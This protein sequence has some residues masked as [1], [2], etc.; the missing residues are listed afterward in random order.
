MRILLLPLLFFAI[1]LSS[2]SKEDVSLPDLATDAFYSSFE[3]QTP[4][5]IDTKA[6]TQYSSANPVLHYV[7]TN[8][9]VSTYNTTHYDADV[10]NEE[11][12]TAH[13]KYN[14]KLSVPSGNT[15]N[16]ITINGTR[17]NLLQFHFHWASEHTIDGVKSAMEVHLVHQST[18]GKLAV[19]GVLINIGAKNNALQ[20]VFDAS[21]EIDGAA[22]TLASF[23]PASLLPS[24]LDHYF[25]Y[26]GSLT[27]PGGG[28]K[29]LPY[30]EGLDW[31]VYKAPLTIT[32]AQLDQYVKI[33][34]EP[35]A[36]P[37]QPL[38]GRTVLYHVSK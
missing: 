22:N 32:A 26:S 7:S 38:K 33:Y 27:T 18:A 20:T 36:R 34:E 2:C 3:G 14:L 31:F 35:N 8:G 25:T 10:Q 23:N 19:V 37:V 16:Y 17:F 29:V 24:D 6:V 21:P 4:I 12:P 13:D 9:F 1:V 5:N 28:L 30:L 15:D 11:N